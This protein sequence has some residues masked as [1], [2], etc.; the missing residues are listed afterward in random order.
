MRG[1]TTTLSK[2]A[3]N[4]ENILNIIIVYTLNVIYVSVVYI[5]LT[6]FCNYVF[7][8]TCEKYEKD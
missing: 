7:Y 6:Y 4:S 5:K 2:I 1:N 8:A 3:F